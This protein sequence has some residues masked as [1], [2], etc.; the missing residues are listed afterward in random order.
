M[1]QKIPVSRLVRDKISSRM[2]SPTSNSTQLDEMILLILQLS[3]ER[4]TYYCPLIL[5]T[6]LLRALIRENMVFRWPLPSPEL[7]LQLSIDIMCCWNCVIILPDSRGPKLWIN[8]AEFL[9]S[10]T[11]CLSYNS[12][13]NQRI[14]TNFTENIYLSR[15]TKTIEFRW[16]WPWTSRSFRT[17]TN[18]CTTT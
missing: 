17:Y 1:T 9:L 4:G 14:L 15:R 18:K 11:P 3:P 6:K 12:W 10:I 5:I 13:T 7:Y 8:D 16:P 2:T